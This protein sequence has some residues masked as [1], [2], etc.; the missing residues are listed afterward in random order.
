MKTTDATAKKGTVV[1]NDMLLLCDDPAMHTKQCVPSELP[2]IVIFVHGVNDPGGNYDIIEDGI[3]EGLNERLDAFRLVPGKYGSKFNEAKNSKAQYGDKQYEEF[4]SVM[5]DPDTF[6]YRREE[7]QGDIGRRTHSVFIPF[8]W[9]YRAAMNEIARASQGTEGGPDDYKVVRGQYQD[10]HGNRLSKHFAKGG[11]MFNNATTS[12]PLMYQAGFGANLANA[13]AKTQMSGYEYS[14]QSPH[15]KYMV[16]AAERLAMLIRTIRSIDGDETINI[17]AHSQG[18]LITLL[19]QAILAD[20]AEP[21]RRADCLILV[22]SPYSLVETKAEWIAR[23]NVVRYT[24]R[25]RLETLLSIVQLVTDNIHDQ[26]AL[27]ELSPASPGNTRHRGRT[28]LRW[29]GVG[30]AV[31][32]KRDGTLAR[33]TERENRGKVYMYFCPEDSTVDLLTIK[34]IGT[35]GIP[36][37]L[38]CGTPAMTILKQYRFFQR[39]W[40]RRS[41]DVHG[42]DVRI[43]QAPGY[44]DFGNDQ[45]YFINGEAIFPPFCPKMYGGEEIRGTSEKPG[46]VIP[47]EYTKD[48]RIGNPDEM[49]P[50]YLM[51]EVAGYVPPKAQEMMHEFNDGKDPNDQTYSMHMKPVGDLHGTLRGHRVMREETPNETRSRISAMSSEWQANSYHSAMLSERDNLRCV[52]AYDLAV[53]QAHTLDSDDTRSLLIGLADWKMDQQAYALLESNVMF[54][55][56]SPQAKALAEGCRIYYQSGIFPDHLVSDAPPSSVNTDKL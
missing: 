33:F 43:G 16:L 56:L 52:A 27:P 44:L 28:G 11:G 2:G 10:I 8:Y 14:G 46:M 45:A 47:N 12:I 25:G 3:C 9:G 42:K 48:Q 54:N 38:K 1:E 36:E 22:D 40:S 5:Y 15:R 21:T 6:L 19:A 50:F 34:G 24:A 7:T 55:T 31:S 29:N 35:H 53:G 51:K 17:V 32:R 20:D 41:T 39:A 49:L 18:T 4:A 30:E 13:L 23:N 26:P 37:S